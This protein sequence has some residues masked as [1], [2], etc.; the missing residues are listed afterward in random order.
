MGDPKAVQTPITKSTD[1]TSGTTNHKQVKKQSLAL[2]PDTGKFSVN[3]GDS[4]DDL[5]PDKM[6]N[7][8]EVVETNE[9]DGKTWD[10]NSKM[11]PQ[12]MKRWFGGGPQTDE[13]ISFLFKQQLV[14]I[15]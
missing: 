10:R 2:S 1:K 13:E 8:N 15:G 12:M 14:N 5:D 7:K 11:P 4:L 6:I 3:R 9:E